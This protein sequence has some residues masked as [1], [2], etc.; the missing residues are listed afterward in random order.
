[1]NQE[2][3]KTMEDKI[4]QMRENLANIRYSVADI[5][6]EEDQAH[7]KQKA[8]KSF[9]FLIHS[10]IGTILFIYARPELAI[11]YILLNILSNT[12]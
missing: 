12:L 6:R 7:K 1:M 5:Q 8:Y 11:Y 10:A 9:L 2:S 4:Q 3:Q